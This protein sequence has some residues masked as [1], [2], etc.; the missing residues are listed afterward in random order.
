MPRRRPTARARRRGPR[1]RCAPS[2]RRPGARR[3]RRSRP[4]RRCG[5]RPAHRRRWS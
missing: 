5:R 4:R 1:G 3:R 2:R